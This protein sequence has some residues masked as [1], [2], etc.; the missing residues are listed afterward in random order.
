MSGCPK[1]LLYGQFRVR[2]VDPSPCL[3]T[4]S[5]LF[6]RSLDAKM[7]CRTRLSMRTA[8]SASLAIE[9]NTTMTPKAVLAA[10]ATER[11]TPILP[12]GIESARILIAVGL[13]IS[14]LVVSQSRRGTPME[15]GRTISMRMGR[16]L[17]GPTVMNR[18]FIS[19]EQIAPTAARRRGRTTSLCLSTQYSSV[20]RLRGGN[21][22]LVR[23]CRVAA[24][25]CDSPT[26]R[27]QTGSPSI[28]TGR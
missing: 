6:H 2:Y 12:K 22:K 8:T 5:F 21:T 7:T 17:H 20:I 16:R 9:L 18:E 3:T 24:L 23:P 27:T 11:S 15:P 1:S 25:G 14:I 10:L 28:R 13:N 19:R 26:V 4:P